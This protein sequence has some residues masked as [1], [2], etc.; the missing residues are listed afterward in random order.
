M[1]VW[2]DRGARELT[3]DWAYSRDTTAEPS[4]KSFLRLSA[5]L[6]LSALWWALSL[7][8]ALSLKILRL[9]AF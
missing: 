8:M 7:K 5:I 2:G 3:S 9:S 1:D 6:R 4:L